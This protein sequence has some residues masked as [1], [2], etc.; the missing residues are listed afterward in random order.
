MRRTAFLVLLLA[1][2]LGSA[3]A[4]KCK[5]YSSDTLES[6][7]AVCTEE[8]A[9]QAANNVVNCYQESECVGS[10]SC[11]RTHQTAGDIKIV[12]GACAKS[13]YTCADLGDIQNGG[14]GECTTVCRPAPPTLRSDH[15]STVPFCRRVFLQL[16][17]FQRSL[18]PALATI[19][20]CHL[21]RHHAPTGLVQRRR[22]HPLCCVA[23]PSVGGRRPR[24]RRPLDRPER[25]HRRR[26]EG[27]CTAAFTA[28]I[29]SVPTQRFAVSA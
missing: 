28:P 11:I 13:P 10:T 20:E 27:R 18:F 2:A 9:A 6:P 24:V 22:W 25:G 1:A 5:A 7:T 23:D 29:R 14:C 16:V 4:I 19:P 15:C 8:Q 3:S 26:S 21:T 12:M 17:F